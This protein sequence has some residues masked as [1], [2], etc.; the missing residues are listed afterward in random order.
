ME[1][2]LFIGVPFGL[3]VLLAPE[4]LIVVISYLSQ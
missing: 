4:I 2:N 1:M 3:G